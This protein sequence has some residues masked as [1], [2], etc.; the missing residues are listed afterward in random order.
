AMSPFMSAGNRM[1]SA[2][3]LRFSYAAL[4]GPMSTTRL[5]CKT[6]PTNSRPL[7]SNVPSLN[8]VTVVVA[9]IP[10]DVATQAMTP[11]ITAHTDPLLS[12]LMEP[13]VFSFELVTAR[14]E[15]AA[16]REWHPRNRSG[17]H[18]REQGSRHSH[19]GVRPYMD[20]LRP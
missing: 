18:R 13:P 9:V 11:N 6:S 7:A 3:E 2:L 15:R 8:G 5:S 14:P 1:R 12:A 10:A 17:G 20:G 4:A 19:P 16:L